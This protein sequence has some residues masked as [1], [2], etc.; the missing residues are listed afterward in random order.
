MGNEGKGRLQFC[1]G[2]IVGWSSGRIR[3]GTVWRDMSV[4]AGSQM[5]GCQ[6]PGC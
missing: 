2:R 5:G 1:E 3:I 4:G 6:G